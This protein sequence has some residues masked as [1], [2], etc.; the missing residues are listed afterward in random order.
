MAPEEARFR[1]LGGATTSA[2]RSFPA[3]GAVVLLLARPVSFHLVSRK[4]LAVDNEELLTM[5][6]PV[7]SYPRNIES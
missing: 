4:V 6:Y 3:A 2:F 1:P 7:V 5:N